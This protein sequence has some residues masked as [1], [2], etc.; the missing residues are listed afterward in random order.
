MEWLH[1]LVLR[2]NDHV[3]NKIEDLFPH[4]NIFILF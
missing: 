2:I 3:I 4:N 1:D